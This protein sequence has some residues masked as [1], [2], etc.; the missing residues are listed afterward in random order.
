MIGAINF[1]LYFSMGVTHT[2]INVCTTLQA[3]GFYFLRV[4]YTGPKAVSIPAVGLG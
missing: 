1:P 4:L 3:S 2:L